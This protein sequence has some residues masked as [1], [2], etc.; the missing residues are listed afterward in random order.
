MEEK[1]PKTNVTVKLVGENGNAFVILA[2]VSKELQSAGYN[3]E[4]IKEFVAKATSSD[5][6]HLLA[7]VSEYVHVQ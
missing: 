5:Y 3:K 4:F 7:T 2:R 1:T 6:L